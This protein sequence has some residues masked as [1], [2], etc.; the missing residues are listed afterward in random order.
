VE[1]VAHQLLSTGSRIVART[2]SSRMCLPAIVI[3]AVVGYAVRTR[4]PR[5]P[6]T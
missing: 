2:I 6:A 5:T 1:D 4:T 3:Q